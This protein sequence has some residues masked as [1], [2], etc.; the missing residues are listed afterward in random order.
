MLG[1]VDPRFQRNRQVASGESL[2]Q[3]V[4]INPGAKIRGAERR[5]EY[6][7]RQLARRLRHALPQ[8]TGVA[9]VGRAVCWSFTCR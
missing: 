4:L 2:V 6:C 1:Q 9:A 3:G 7:A 5:E 8:G